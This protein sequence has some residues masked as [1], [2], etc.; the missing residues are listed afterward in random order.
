M[1][2]DE[3]KEQ[4]LQAQTTYVTNVRAKKSFAQAKESL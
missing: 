2:I 3:E 1:E 4:G